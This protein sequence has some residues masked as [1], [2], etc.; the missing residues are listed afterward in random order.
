MTRYSALLA[1]ASFI[2]LSSCANAPDESTMADGSNM[3]ELAMAVAQ[4]TGGVY[5]PQDM[6]QGMQ[7]HMPQ[8]NMPGG[9]PTNMQQPTGS[10]KV[11]MHPIMDSKTG[12]LAS[13]MPLPD[14][15]RITN[16]KNP[17]TRPLWGQ[18]ESRSSTV[19]AVHTSTATTA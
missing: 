3:D 6:Q 19:K 7:Q 13:Q 1:L 4:R 14:T 2:L 17:R 18:A 16:S 10:G 12:M 8:D 15:W 11:V 9:V 5:V